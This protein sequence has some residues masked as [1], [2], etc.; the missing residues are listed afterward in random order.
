MAVLGR[1]MSGNRLASCLRYAVTLRFAA[2]RLAPD[3]GHSRHAFRDWLSTDRPELH[4]SAHIE[5]RI[6]NRLTLVL[7]VSAII[8]AAVQFID[9]R[10]Q[11]SRIEN[12]ARGMSTRFAGNY[13]KNM[14]DISDVVGHAQR[15][16]DI[17]VDLLGYGQIA[18]HDDFQKYYQTLE[19]FGSER[20]VSVRIL[21]YSR[22]RVKKVQD[23]QF[24]E[25][26]YAKDYE[27]KTPRLQLFF[28]R[29][30]NGVFPKEKK[31]FDL[32]LMQTLTDYMKNLMAHG[33]RIKVTS[34]DLP[35]YLWNEDD[36]EAV[37]SFVKEAASTEV[38]FRTRDNALLD[39]FE[40]SFSQLW[41]AADDADV[42]DPD[43]RK[44]RRTIA[45]PPAGGVAAKPAATSSP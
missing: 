10:I 38:S 34:N 33:V 25:A 7:A 17:M 1:R 12:L 41:Q 22:D 4:A 30:N 43:W 9:S 5:D 39:P 19:S 18:A 44:P 3:D 37:V 21:I 45:A 36:Q 6:L 40:T 15:S 11:E 26:Q 16:L 42:N 8:F 13:P 32:I 20:R 35:F 14:K 24:T 2:L 27:A 28:N 23:T 29:H 31:T